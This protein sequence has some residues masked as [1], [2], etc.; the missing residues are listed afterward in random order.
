M[1]HQE[2]SRI[3]RYSAYLLFFI[4]AF[5]FGCN[6]GGGIDS[7]ST[8]Q[9]QSA[10]A[11]PAP[12]PL[13]TV[14]FSCCS[15]PSDLPPCDGPLAAGLHECG[16]SYGG[17]N[18]YYQILMPSAYTGDKAVPLVL[19]L[20]G[21]SSPVVAGI[22][23]ERLVSGMD[24]VAEREGFIVVYPEGIH[25]TWRSK[26]LLNTPANDLGDQGFLLALVDSIKKNRKI[27][28][29]RVYVMGISMG[30]AMTQIMGCE[31]SE[32]FAAIAPVSFQLPVAPKD[33]K[34]AATMPVIYFHSPDD[35]LVPWLG[36]LV[37]TSV[38]GLSAPDSFAAWG[39]IDGCTDTPKTYYS[40][41]NSSCSSYEACRDGASVAFCSIN[42]HNQI[43][44]GHLAYLN[45]DYVP[46]SEMI[47]QFFTRY[48]R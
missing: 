6:G 48:R 37:F 10:A 12:K 11:A 2:V 31:A 18:R 7:A 34:P 47:W 5:L 43:L 36:A 15:G 14:T 30:A 21:F 42:G 23:G 35:W 19:D 26:F 41:G 33:C 32:V 28:N 4:S 46:I 39:A 13:T 22:S 3:A 27:D 9:P 16:F 8:E 24:K 38:P 29:A 40:K 1:K 45:D 44:G 17:K 20:H 25:N